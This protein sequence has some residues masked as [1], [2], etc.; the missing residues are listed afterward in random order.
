VVLNTNKNN[1]KLA[2]TWK[3]NNALL[4]DTLVKEEIKKEVRGLLEFNE[5][6]DT[7]YQNVW[8][9]T[10]AVVRGKLIAL[11]TSKKKLERADTSCLAAHLITLEQK[12]ANSPKRCRWQEI[13][14]LRAE[15]NQIETKRIIQRINQTR[16]LFFEKVN[17][18]E[19]P[20]SR[21]TIGH[22]DSIQINKIRNE[23][24]DITMKYI[25]K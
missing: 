23:K 12:E 4:N 7:S 16:S 22:R 19:K 11:S 6:E 18:I 8:D 10:K 2:Y 17:K 25:L 15:V 1:R 20:L 5:S 21:L 13:I 9:T 24:E 3:L 14:K